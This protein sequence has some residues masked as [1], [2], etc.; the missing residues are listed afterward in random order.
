M[1]HAIRTMIVRGAPLIGAAAAYGVALAMRRTRP[2]MRSRA[3]GMLQ[4]TRPTARNLRWALNR[5]CDALAQSPARERAACAWNE[6][7]AICDADVAQCRAI[8]AHGLPISAT[9]ANAGAG[10]LN[11]LTHCN[12]GWLAWSIGAPRSRRSTPP[13][14]Q[15]SRYTSGWTRRARAIRALR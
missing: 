11:V 2:T 8:G 14:T 12:A 10:R 15:A 6:A 7:A 5:M 9:L 4:G 3:H 13:T 1:A